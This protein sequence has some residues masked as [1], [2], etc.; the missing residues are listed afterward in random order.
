MNRCYIAGP[1]AGL[2]GHNFLAFERAA[3]WLRRRE[4]DVASPHENDFGEGPHERGN[5]PHDFYMRTDIAQLVRCDAIVL[6][7]GW[8]ASKGARIELDVALG[9][10][11][12][13][14][15]FDGVALH[16]MA[17]DAPLRPLAAKPAV[18]DAAHLARQRDFSHH[19]FGPGRRTKGVVAHIRKELQEIED[20]P[21]DI[22]EWVDVVI[23]ALDGA[24]RAGWEPQQIID[25]IKAK[26]ARNEARTWPDWRTASEDQPIEHDRTAEDDAAALREAEN[27]A[28]LAG[29]E[30]GGWWLTTAEDWSEH[31]QEQEDCSCCASSGQSLLRHG[32][33]MP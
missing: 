7:P 18:I 2:P 28:A 9:L 10:G 11:M 15:F 13:V 21:T 33:M 22:T 30:K 24:W 1:M 8:P 14:Y 31:I 27:M 19:T 16:S 25:A 3:A 17:R 26:Q 4:W 23:L 32:R 20:D 6:L 5:M 29:A 12:A